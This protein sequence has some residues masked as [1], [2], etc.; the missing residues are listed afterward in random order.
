MEPQLAIPASVGFPNTI[1]FAALER[2]S[3]LPGG[4]IEVTE[5]GDLVRSESSKQLALFAGRGNFTRR[6]INVLALVHQ[7]SFL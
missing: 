2:P 3:D 7:I 4:L 1:L 6:L 5:Y